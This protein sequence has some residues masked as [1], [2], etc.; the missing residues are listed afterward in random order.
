MPKK[1][2]YY[3]EDV[4]PHHE[5]NKSFVKQFFGDLTR[6]IK[7]LADNDINPYSII[8]SVRCVSSG[9]FYDEDVDRAVMTAR[10][11]A[12]AA[13]EIFMR[14]RL[15]LCS[16]P[17]SGILTRGTIKLPGV[18]QVKNAKP[19]A[20]KLDNV[21]FNCLKNGLTHRPKEAAELLKHEIPNTPSCF[22]AF[23]GQLY[24]SICQMFLAFFQRIKWMLIRLKKIPQF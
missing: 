8:G 20:L 4:L 24:H 16:E 18:A 11:N 12:E 2:G 17:I 15:I 22:A 6:L 19:K 21:T 3:I 9:I 14:K 10:E 13:A 5:D 7:L 1:Y 23:T